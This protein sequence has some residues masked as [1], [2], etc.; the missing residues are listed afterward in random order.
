MAK[1]TDAALAP[2]HSPPSARGS[3]SRRDARHC[4]NGSCF[5]V[6]IARYLWATTQHRHSPGQRMLLKKL[7]GGIAVLLVKAERDEA[8]RMESATPMAMPA[9]GSLDPSDGPWR[10]ASNLGAGAM[11]P[12]NHGEQRRGVWRLSSDDHSRKGKEIVTRARWTW[13]RGGAE[14]QLS[15][16]QEG[17]GGVYGIPAGQLF[18]MLGP[19]CMMAFLCVLCTEQVTSADTAGGLNGSRRE[20]TGRIR[21]S[22]SRTG[23][24]DSR[25]NR[26]GSRRTLSCRHPAA[27]VCQLAAG[28]WSSL[29]RRGGRRGGIW[30]RARLRHMA[31]IGGQY[32][33]NGAGAGA[34]PAECSLPNS[35]GGALCLCCS[36]FF[37]QISSTSTMYVNVLCGLNVEKGEKR[38]GGVPAGAQHEVIN[39]AT[40]AGRR[41]ANRRAWLAQDAA[42]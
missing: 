38:R 37:C 5:Q 14:Q 17:V 28:V 25:A 10:R 8:E 7:E 4:T 36:W 31:C 16:S 39:T 3:G 12:D 20:A 18:P 27:G 34:G 15:V 40:P 11:V 13:R 26:L 1:T 29:W 19:K 42:G 24:G 32:Q 2:L 30:T 21:F 6:L 35:C 9:R 41:H 22:P 23:M 33:S